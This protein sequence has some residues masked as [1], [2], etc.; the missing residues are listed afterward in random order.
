MIAVCTHVAV[1]VITSASRMTR[2]KTDVTQF[3]VR[4][5]QISDRN[6]LN[7]LVKNI[8]PQCIMAFQVAVLP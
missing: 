4:S 3:N 6:V 7:E 8:G 1:V 2:F 5:A